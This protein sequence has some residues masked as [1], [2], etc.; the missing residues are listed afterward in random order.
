VAAAAVAA[1]TPAKKKEGSGGMIVLLF[2]GV[3]GLA[4]IAAGAFFYVKSQRLDFPTKS[5]VVE[6]PNV[7]KPLPTAS[8]IGPATDTPP[9]ATTDTQTAQVDPKKPGPALKPPPGGGFKPAPTVSV[10]PK[11]VVKDLPQNAAGGGNDLNSAMAAAAGPIASSTG[12][13]STGGGGGGGNVAQKPSQGMV[14]GAINAVLPQARGCLGPDDPRSIANVVFQSDGTVKSV[15]V[16][17]GNK[18]A[19]GCI[20]S[21]LIKAKVQPFAEPTFAFPVTVR[22]TGS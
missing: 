16:T 4:A 7:T 2:G 19:E 14:Q 5:A 10:D 6:T 15:T 9:E 17:G 13:A 8:S 12:P 11:L 3:V 18:D 21:A 1:P 20:K 22:P